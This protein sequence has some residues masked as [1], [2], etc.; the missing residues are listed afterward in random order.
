MG[1]NV[2]TWLSARKCPP[3][4][5]KAASARSTPRWS[6]WTSG[7]TAVQGWLAA[8]G[9]GA[10]DAPATATSLPGP[11]ACGGILCAQT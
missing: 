6:H 7:A 9:P 5:A 2:K 3:H 4:E 11:R 8:P 10:V 1:E